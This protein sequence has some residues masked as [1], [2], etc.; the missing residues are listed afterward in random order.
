MRGHSKT[1]GSTPDDQPAPP[2]K[3]PPLKPPNFFDF[4]ENREDIFVES[5]EAL[6]KKMRDDA[7]KRVKQEA[8]PYAPDEKVETIGEAYVAEIEERA[9]S[10]MKKKAAGSDTPPSHQFSSPAA[11][12]PLPN[13]DSPISTRDLIR[14]DDKI[15]S[16]ERQLED[17]KVSRWKPPPMY[18]TINRILL[19]QSYSLDWYKTLEEKVALLDAAIATNDGNCII[20]ILLF[21]RRTLDHH[22][23]VGVLLK[24]PVAGRHYCSFLKQLQAWSE[25]SSIYRTLSD[26]KSYGYLRLQQCEQADDPAARVKQLR[27]CYVT[28]TSTPELKADAQYVDEYIKLT[29]K[30]LR[31]EEQD[32]R[33]SANIGRAGNIIFTPLTTTLLYCCR[34]H[35]NEPD[36]YVS[37][38]H[39]KLSSFQGHEN[40]A[41]SKR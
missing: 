41:V 32:V 6:V 3:S 9:I 38:T 29:E 1:V 17:L 10:T 11:S 18:E 21:I 5:P 22:I 28:F 16:L 19:G 2:L 4:D 7:K 35:S 23:L 33:G 26:Y 13:R 27:A 39:H 30:Q 14:R 37:K 25:L 24:K 8:K 12:K 34:F 15:A 31:I 20:A 40:E 36:V